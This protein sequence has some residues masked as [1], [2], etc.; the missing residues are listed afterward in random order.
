[1]VG[2]QQWQQGSSGDGSRGAAA[3]VVVHQ[4]WQQ[5]ISGG[6]GATAAAAG[7]QQHCYFSLFYLHITHT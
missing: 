7:Q 1:M 3:K 6:S 4:R 2:Q 5:G